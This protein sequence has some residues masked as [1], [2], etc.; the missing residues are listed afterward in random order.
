MVHLPSSFSKESRLQFYCRIEISMFTG[1]K[2]YSL[3]HVRL[4]IPKMSTQNPNYENAVFTL[5]VVYFSLSWGEVTIQLD[6][7]KELHDCPYIHSI[8]SYSADRGRLR[9]ACKSPCSHASSADW[10]S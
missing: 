10:S 2:L 1:T 4:K 9:A 7:P 6:C 3:H 8:H 5:Y